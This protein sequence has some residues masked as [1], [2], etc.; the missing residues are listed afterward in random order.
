MRL[1]QFLAALA[2]TEGFLRCQLAP[3]KL[4][5]LDWL[6]NCKFIGLEICAFMAGIAEGL[7]ETHAATTPTIDLIVYFRIFDKNRSFNG[8]YWLQRLVG[9][10]PGILSLDLSMHLEVEMRLVLLAKGLGCIWRLDDPALSRH[11]LHLFEEI[12]SG[13]QQHNYYLIINLMKHNSTR[14]S[15]QHSNASFLD[16]PPIC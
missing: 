7:L 9:T 14:T 13:P 8:G 16:L 3:A 4:N 1:L 2:I 6:L 5:I 11:F 12:A 10:L 15:T